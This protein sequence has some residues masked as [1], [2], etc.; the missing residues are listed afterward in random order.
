M[1]S[2]DHER[3]IDLIM[4]RSTED[5]AATELSWLEVHL[6]ACSA[7]AQY[8]ADFNNTG[9]L[10]RATAVTASPALVSKTQARVRERAIYLREQRTRTVL[11]AISFC[12][13]ATLSAASG[14]LWWRF[15]AWVAERVGLSLAVAEPGVV[16]FL[17]LPAIAVAVLMLAFPHSVFEPAVMA[18]LGREREG[19]RQ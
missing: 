8:D 9:R 2:H 1:T 14:W 19:V 15:G 17:L 12:L 18:A 16:V 3:A 4:R 10:L 7:C 6:E 13:G 11:I 5:L